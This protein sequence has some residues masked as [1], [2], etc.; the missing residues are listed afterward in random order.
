[1]PS[2]SVPE[3]PGGFEHRFPSTDPSAENTVSGTAFLSI[4][5]TATDT[6]DENGQRDAE[7]AGHRRAQVWPNRKIYKVYPP[8][9]PFRRR[10]TLPCVVLPAFS[11]RWYSAATRKDGAMRSEDPRVL[12]IGV[13][14][15]LAQGRRSRA[16]CSRPSRNSRPASGRPE[17][18]TRGWR[19]TAIVRRRARPAKHAEGPPPP[20]TSGAASRLRLRK[21]A[22]RQA[23]DRTPPAQRPVDAAA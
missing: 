15:M 6:D 16:G 5:W 12:D 22:A 1:M 2:D 4:A 3:R 18:K 11:A 20:E 7:G 8:A 9:R 23:A 13:G 21:T 17:R 19:A 10:L 14:A